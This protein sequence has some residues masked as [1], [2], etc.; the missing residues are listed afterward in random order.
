MT[1]GAQHT[2]CAAA[3]LSPSFCFLGETITPQSGPTTAP[4]SWVNSWSWFVWGFPS[5]DRESPVVWTQLSSGQ[6][7]RDQISMCSVGNN[8]PASLTV[9]VGT[10]P[11]FILLG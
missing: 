5:L 11:I 2:D 4:Y 10:Q 3:G 8:W 9:I 6:G 1:L 7:R